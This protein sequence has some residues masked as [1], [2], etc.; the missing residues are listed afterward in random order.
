MSTFD[1]FPAWADKLKS[2]QVHPTEA[3]KVQPMPVVSF[4]DPELVAKLE[5]DFASADAHAKID[6]AR[7][8]VTR[9]GWPKGKPRKVK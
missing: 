1:Q 9:K 2:T 8:I 5:A 4:A 6:P 7:P 3:P